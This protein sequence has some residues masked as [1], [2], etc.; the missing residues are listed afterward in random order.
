MHDGNGPRDATATNYRLLL[1][2]VADL[3]LE[4]DRLRRHP[5]DLNRQ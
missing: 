2:Y 5:T 1:A 4:V 3:E